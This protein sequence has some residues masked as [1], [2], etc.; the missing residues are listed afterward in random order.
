M[1]TDEHRHVRARRALRP[2]APRLGAHHGRGIPLRILRDRRTRPRSGHRGAHPIDARPGG[3][4]CRRPG[5]RRR[6]RDR[7][8]GVRPRRGPRAASVLGI[9]T[10]ASGVAAATALAA[11]RGLDGAT[12]E[13]RDGTDNGLDDGSFDVVWVLESSHLMRD[14]DGPAARVRAGPRPGGSPRAV[15]HHSQARHPVPRGAVRGVRT[16][17]RSAEPSATPT[18]CLS[19]STPRPSTA[20]RDD[21]HRRLGHQPADAADLRRLAG[22]RRHAR[23]PPAPR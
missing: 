21:D 14:K 4:Q 8:P 10:S 3:H 5:P 11:G 13:Q 20:C 17:R 15:R 12:F 7:P 19:T 9:T 18:W 2:C 1:G 16:S 6:M 22:Q 23:G